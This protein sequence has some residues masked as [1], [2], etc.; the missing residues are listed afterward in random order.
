VDSSRGWTVN[1][2]TR[3]EFRPGSTAYLVYT[4]GASTDQLISQNGSLSPWRDLSL[5]NR[6]PSDDA[7][8]LKVSWMFR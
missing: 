5:L 7:V 6:L 2:I 3:W 1:L 4:H 8:Q